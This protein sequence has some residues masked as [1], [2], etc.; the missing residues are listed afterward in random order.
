LHAL[1]SDVVR[2]SSLPLV[3]RLLTPHIG[4]PIPLVTALYG[5]LHAAFGVQPMAFHALSLLVHL[6]NVALVFSLCLRFATGAL[7][8]AL[9]TG[10]WALHPVLAEPVSWVTGLKDLLLLTGALVATHGALDLLDVTRSR[11]R[12]LMLL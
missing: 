4:Y 7:P 12:S 2:W 3:D 8:A 10:L 9:A 5:L 6:L 1:H 11:G